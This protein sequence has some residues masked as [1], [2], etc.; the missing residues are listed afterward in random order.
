MIG[1]ILA[2]EQRRATF[3]NPE[4]DGKLP[5]RLWFV[6]EY[7]QRKRRPGRRLFAFPNEKI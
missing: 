1:E 2:K 4:C 7:N 6:A 3:I 5:P